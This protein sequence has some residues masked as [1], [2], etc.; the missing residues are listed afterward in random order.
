VDL[1]K[2]LSAEHSRSAVGDRRVGNEVDL[3]RALSNDRA[4][5]IAFASKEAADKRTLI[6]SA[7]LFSAFQLSLSRPATKQVALASNCHIANRDACAGTFS[8]L[9]E[10]VIAYL[11]SRLM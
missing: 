8:C 6:G 4:E 1:K 3:F 9:R 10:C 11:I 7:D 2:L 5:T